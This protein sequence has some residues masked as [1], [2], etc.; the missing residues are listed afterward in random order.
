M[1]EHVERE[2]RRHW[3]ALIRPGLITVALVVVTTA[4]YMML[5]ATAVWWLALLAV[6]AAYGHMAVRAWEW[7][8]LRVYLTDRRLFMTSGLLTRRIAAMPLDKLTDLTFEQSPTGRMLGYGR[9]VVE[10]A[11]QQQALESIPYI[12]DPDDFY[13]TVAG[14]VFGRDRRAS[15]GQPPP[16][17]Q[18]PIQ[19]TVNPADPTNP[20]GIPTA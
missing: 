8:I 19:I 18:P 6:V 12:P 11:G 5:S 20:D 9:L 3:A 17:A 15:D 7:W 4:L 16:V 13:Q 2:V 10:S 14:L 1:G